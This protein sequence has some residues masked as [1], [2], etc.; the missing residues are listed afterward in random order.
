MSCLLGLA[1]F[2]LTILPRIGLDETAEIA[3]DKLIA[4]SVVKKYGRVMN[5][6]SDE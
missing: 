6:M 1:V 4:E 5:A 2:H 3:R